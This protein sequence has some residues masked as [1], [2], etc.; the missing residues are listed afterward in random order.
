MQDFPHMNNNLAKIAALAARDQLHQRAPFEPVARI[1]Y[2]SQGRLLVVG[3]G[4]RIK[5][6]LQT[7]QG[8]LSVA[9]F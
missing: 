9:V 2:L 5:Q 7:L 3:E 6:A 4:E 1:N 8:V